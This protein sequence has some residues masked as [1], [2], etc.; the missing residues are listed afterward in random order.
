MW[1]HSLSFRSPV[2]LITVAGPFII[3][4]FLVT[5]TP[6]VTLYI[7]FTPLLFMGFCL[8]FPYV[9]IGD[10]FIFISR[11]RIGS[12]FIRHFFVLLDTVHHHVG[13]FYFTVPCLLITS[14][15]LSLLCGSPT[16]SSPTLSPILSVVIFV[17]VI[18]LFLFG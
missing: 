8:W 17:T 3:P 14:L 12:V 13:V 18:I 10:L 9:F 6:C 5:V 15:F 16:L 11:T 1:E 4:V 7:F 2:V